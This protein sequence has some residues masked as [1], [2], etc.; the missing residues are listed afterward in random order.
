MEPLVDSFKI[1][2]L[3]IP[4]FFSFRD[5]VALNALKRSN[6]IH[7]RYFI[8][9]KLAP[10]SRVTSVINCTGDWELELQMSKMS[11]PYVCSQ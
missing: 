5:A 9:Q 2:W 3:W 8:L 1:S 4:F 6:Y 7:M 10:S 11:C